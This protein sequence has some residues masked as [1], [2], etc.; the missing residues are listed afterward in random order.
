MKVAQSVKLRFVDRLI[1]SRASALWIIVVIGLLVSCDG[2]TEPSLDKS[3]VAQ[4]ESFL[5]SPNVPLRDREGY[6]VFLVIG[7]SNTHYGLGIDPVRDTAPPDTFQLGRGGDRDLKLLPADEPLDH[8]SKGTSD[9][10][11]KIPALA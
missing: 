9:L 1:G 4:D 11:Q 6:D 7:Q 5:E 10:T 3:P 2:T 8:F